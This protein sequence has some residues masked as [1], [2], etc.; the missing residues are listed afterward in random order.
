MSSTPSRRAVLRAA[1][2]SAPAVTVAAAA[3]ATAASGAG[4]LTVTSSGYDPSQ[5]WGAFAG[6]TASP[7][8]AGGLS[9]DMVTTS[10]DVT[11]TRWVA[12]NGGRTLQ[13]FFRP[14]S[15]SEP[16][17][18]VTILLPGYAPLVHD[19]GTPVV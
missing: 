11:I 19:F 14:V 17:V 12:L 3:P 7:A 13:L 1:A 18:R 10:V 15:L 8:Y 4:T 5:A 6:I 16:G 2:W 9:T